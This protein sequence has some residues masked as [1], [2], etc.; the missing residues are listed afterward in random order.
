MPWLT[1]AM[2]V[3][4]MVGA[5]ISDVRT[6]RIPN[7][8]IGVG[9]VLAL[10]LQAVSGFGALGAA[11]LGAG[12]ALVIAFP[13]FALGVIGG[14]DAKLFLVVGAFMGPG[15]FVYALL[16]SAIVGGLLAIVVAIHRGAIL[17]VL[18]GCKDLVVHAVTLGRRGGRPTLDQP[19][20]IT[21]PYGAAIALGSIAAWLLLPG[22]A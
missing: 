9:L 18:L 20:A 4:V 6:N 15:G 7:R 22:A 2:F 14:G 3:A 16:A 17:P 1:T 5:M 11:A 19:G 8:L 12:L 21:V 13:M 10:T